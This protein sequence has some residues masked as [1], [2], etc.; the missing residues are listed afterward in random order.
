VLNTELEFKERAARVLNVGK[1]E[2]T[3][4]DDILR[5]SWSTLHSLSGLIFFVPTL[6][7][8]PWM[9]SM[10]KSR[11]Y[12][13]CH[14]GRRPHPILPHILLRTHILEPHFSGALL[15]WPLTAAVQMMGAR[16]GKVTEQG[17]APRA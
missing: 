2:K 12:K 8:A 14:W 15:T 3:M 10:L 11:W 5:Q 1:P 13:R 9:R 7:P 4:I 6:A 17:L 16:I